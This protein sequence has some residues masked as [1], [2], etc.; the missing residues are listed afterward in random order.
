MGSTLAFFMASSLANSAHRNRYDLNL[1][2]ELSWSM[3]QLN[4]AGGLGNVFERETGLDVRN[5]H[6]I[7]AIADWVAKHIARTHNLAP[8]RGFHGKRDWDPSWGNMGYSP[9]HKAIGEAGRSSPSS[10]LHPNAVPPP[11]NKEDDKIINVHLDGRLL[12][13]VV[14]RR[15]V[16]AHRFAHGTGDHDGRAG[17]PHVDY[18]QVARR[19]RGHPQYAGRERI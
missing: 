13:H 5:P 4:R 9:N 17:M 18:N 3:F 19:R 12:G 15:I 2:G 8:W 7:P 16:Q 1:K 6:S 10:S 14:E 11:K